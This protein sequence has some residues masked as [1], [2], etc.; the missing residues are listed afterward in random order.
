MAS[1]ALGFGRL[2][3][4]LFG[5]SFDLKLAVQVVVPITRP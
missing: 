4:L 1:M 5:G 3:V 2:Q